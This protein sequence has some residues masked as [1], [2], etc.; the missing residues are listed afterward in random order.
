[1][2]KVH[3]LFERP[4]APAPADPTAEL[5]TKLAGALEAEAAA[6]RG[7]GAACLA[8]EQ[9]DPGADVDAS[10][11]RLRAAVARR[12]NIEAAVEPAR[13]DAAGGRGRIRCGAW[14]RGTRSKQKMLARLWRPPAA[15]KFEPRAREV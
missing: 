8:A 3:S 7:H 14:G 13:L 10:A 6:R 1:M 11:E 15:K 9:G 2:G 4:D 12:R 5:E